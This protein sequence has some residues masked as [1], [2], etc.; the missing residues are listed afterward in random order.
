M[1]L[2]APLLPSISHSTSIQS[3]NLI[4]VL[5]HGHDSIK[6]IMT[7]EEERVKEITYKNGHYGL[8]GCASDAHKLVGVSF[9]QNTWVGH[10]PIRP[11]LSSTSATCAHQP[12]TH[13]AGSH[14]LLLAPTG[15]ASP[16]HS[17]S[18]AHPNPKPYL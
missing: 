11:Q 3:T 18:F 2:L 15:T 6:R 12:T 13:V 7:R 9:L 14:A 17:S 1:C 4:E 10:G 16:L 5:C 8:L